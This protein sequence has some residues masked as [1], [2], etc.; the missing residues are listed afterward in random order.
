MSL[1]PL[2]VCPELRIVAFIVRCQD[3]ENR[4]GAAQAARAC[5]EAPFTG[6]GG[7]LLSEKQRGKVQ[8]IDRLGL[9][10][11][12]SLLVQ[13]RLLEPRLS[14]PLLSHT[15]WQQRCVARHLPPART[16]SCPGAAPGAGRN[17]GKPGLCRC[18]LERGVAASMW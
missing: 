7:F 10:L 9:N 4:G 1:I 13:R 12:H 14:S 3:K 15:H 6:A 17:K 5:W 18:W 2:N 11:G 16:L 8:G